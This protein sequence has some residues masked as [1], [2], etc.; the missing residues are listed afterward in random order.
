MLADIFGDVPYEVLETR[1]LT[2]HCSCS[3]ERSLQ[4]LRLLDQDDLLALIAEGEAVIDCHFCHERYTFD[5]AVLE[6]VL[7]ELGARS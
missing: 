2:F 4:A 7:A 6:G 3:R 5:R 1:S